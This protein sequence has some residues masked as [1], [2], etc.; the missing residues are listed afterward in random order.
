MIQGLILEMR[1]NE[2]R[3]HLEA[4][5]KYHAS[6][7]EVY[8]AK[9][10]EETNKQILGED[11]LD[12]DEGFATMSNYGGGMNDL[13]KAKSHRTKAAFFKF[14]AQYLIPDETYRLSE[15]DLAKFELTAGLM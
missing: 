1:T 9:Y 3:E 2:L 5:A 15:T 8:L 14:V 12:A 6:R 13:Q 10:K 4:R 7:R 11:E